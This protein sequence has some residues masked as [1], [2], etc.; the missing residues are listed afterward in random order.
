MAPAGGGDVRREIVEVAAQVAGGVARRLEGILRRAVV[1]LVDD[2]P[3]AQIAQVEG[4]GIDEAE[5]FGIYGVASSP[6]PGAEVLVGRVGG[7]PDHPVVLASLDRRYRPKVA[8]GEAVL[9]DDA[10]GE[11]RVSGGG[12]FLGS[13]ATSGVARDGDDVEVTIPVDTV[14]VAVTG[15]GSSPAVAVLNPTPITLYGRITSASAEVSS[16]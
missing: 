9:H 15:G 1:R 6:P 8:Q 2:A 5:V 12:I 7:A 3:L 11:V 10:G 13:G 4:D 14:V 16:K